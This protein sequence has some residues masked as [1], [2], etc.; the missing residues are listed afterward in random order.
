MHMYMYVFE[1][2]ENGYGYLPTA[3]RL[4]LARAPYHTPYTTVTLQYHSLLGVHYPV[5]LVL[6]QLGRLESRPRY[7]QGIFSA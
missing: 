1:A 2:K 5:S 6:H 4:L 3:A 7:G